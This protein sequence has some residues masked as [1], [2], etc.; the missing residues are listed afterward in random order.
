LEV[1]NNLNLCIKNK[2]SYVFSKFP[3]NSK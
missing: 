3:L 2:K 1:K